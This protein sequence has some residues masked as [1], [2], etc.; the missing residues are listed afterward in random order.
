MQDFNHNK[1]LIQMKTLK[2]IFIISILF[3]VASCDLDLVNPNAATE[4]DVLTTKDGLIALAIGTRQVFSV[5]ALGPVLLTPS[6]TTRETAAMTTFA[7]LEELEQ[8]GAQLSGE[9]GYTNRI[10]V[11]VMRAKGMAENLIAGLD[12]VDLDPGTESGLRAWGH[13]FKAL[14][15]GYLAHNYTHVAID[16]ELNNNAVFADRTDAYN[17]AVSLLTDAVSVLS[18]NAPSSEFMSSV[19][20]DIDLLNSCNALL[21]RYQLMSGNYSA[22]ISAADK[23][24]LSSK[25]VFTYDGQNRNPLFEGLVVDIISYAPRSDFGLPAE[26]TIDA[27]DGRVG[28]YLDPD[29][30]FNSLNNL[31]VSFPKAPW[32][33]DATADIPVYLPGEMLL[34]K[35]EANARDGNLAA[36]EAALNQLRQK[37]AGEDVFGLGAGLTDTYSS[38]GDANAL[39]NEIYKNRRLELLLTGMSLEDSR[40]FNRPEPPTAIDFTAERNRNFYP[41]PDEERASNSNTPPN[42]GI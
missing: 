37:T 32:F 4:G 24:N 6:V 14:C 36:A 29:T 1:T 28:F 3:S 13:M 39:L 33:L 17:A 22:A 10:F 9:N 25:S 27:G 35:A 7:N 20:G 42:P 21:A 23:V 30:T 15:I 16:N 38:G 11:R 8:G 40:R 5:S 12:N 18:A 31:P 2:Y 41:F 34:I 19:S 26:F